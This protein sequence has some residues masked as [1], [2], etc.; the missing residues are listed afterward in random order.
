M[1]YIGL[2]ASSICV[3]CVLLVNSYYNIINLDIQKISSYVIEGNMILE[4]FIT[5]EEQ[6]LEN[7]GEYISRL[8][9]IK[10]CMENSTTSFFTKKYKEYK[11][12]SIENL[13]NTISNDEERNKYLELVNKYNSLCEEELNSLLDKNLFEVTYL[14]TRAYY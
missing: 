6:V 7:K 10:D 8:I 1:K 13:I 14:S 9:N 3:V 12:K 5:R 4:D 2:L 11:V